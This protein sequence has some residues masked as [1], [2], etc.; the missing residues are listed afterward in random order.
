MIHYFIAVCR[1]FFVTSSSVLSLIEV[2][3][4]VVRIMSTMILI[5]F[6][7]AIIDGC[8]GCFL[9]LVF[10]S[11]GRVFCLCR[12]EE[13]SELSI[14]G[15]LY[16]VPSV[17]VRSTINTVSSRWLSWLRH[18]WCH[19]VSPCFFAF[20]VE[21]RVSELSIVGNLYEMPSVV[22]GSKHYK[23]LNR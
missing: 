12:R 6:V 23:C 5:I 21:T 2:P 17:V 16:E 19:V 3:S 22:A 9:C 4:V 7:T 11:E 20:A 14:V 15:T 18:A 13:V 8:P 10:F 1:T